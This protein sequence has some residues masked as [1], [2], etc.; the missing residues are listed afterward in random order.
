VPEMGAGVGIGV[1]GVWILD[2]GDRDGR[3][4]WLLMRRWPLRR[5][6]WGPAVGGLSRSITLPAFMPSSLQWWHEPG[7]YRQAVRSVP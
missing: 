1:C 2:V 6:W 4:R 7:G 5:L 3:P